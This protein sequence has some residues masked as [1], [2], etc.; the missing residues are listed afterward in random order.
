M[1]STIQNTIVGIQF[2][3]ENEPLNINKFGSGVRREGG[4]GGGANNDTV[5]LF[6]RFL[7]FNART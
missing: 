4:W 2:W 7:C 5:I 3:P 1:V 6:I